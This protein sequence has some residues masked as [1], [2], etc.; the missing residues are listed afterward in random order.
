RPALGRPPALHPL[1][2]PRP[3]SRGGGA[4]RAAISRNAR[5]W[6]ASKAA[7]IVGRGPGQLSDHGRRLESMGWSVDRPWRSGP[8]DLSRDDEAGHGHDWRPQDHG[9][10]AVFIGQGARTRDGAPAESAA[11]AGDARALRLRQRH[12]AGCRGKDLWLPAA[13]NNRPLSGERSRWLT[14]E[15]S[16]SVT[17]TRV[18]SPSS[19]AGSL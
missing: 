17:S 8:A 7:A 16:R 10:A 6:R 1:R 11:G 14:R 2:R 18:P 19:P 5:P 9:P 3:I 12:P 4:P 15:A 13:T